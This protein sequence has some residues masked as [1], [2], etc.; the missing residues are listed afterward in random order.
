MCGN[1]AHPL[2]HDIPFPA[3]RRGTKPIFVAK[4]QFAFRSAQAM[5]CQAME[6]NIMAQEPL[7]KCSGH[8]QVAYDW[9][10]I[11]QLVKD[12]D[13]VNHHSGIDLLTAMQ[14]LCHGWTGK[15]TSQWL[16]GQST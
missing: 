5:D 10:E 12:G 8:L 7:Q 15:D 14:R 2:L 9:E 4:P 1:D 6:L 11:L 16:K 3:L 13:D